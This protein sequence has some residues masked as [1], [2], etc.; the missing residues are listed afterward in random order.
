MEFFVPP[1]RGAALVRVLEAGRAT[2]GTRP[3]HC[4]PTTCACASTRPTSSATTPAARPTSS[5]SSPSAG[6][7][8]RASPTAATSTS[9]ST[10][11]TRARSSSTSTR[12]RASATSRTS[13]SPPPAPTARR[14]PSWS[15]PT[16]RRRSRARPAPSSS[17][18]R[19]WRRS[20]SPCCRSCARTA[21]PSSRARS[22]APSAA[23]MQAEY[24]EGGSIGKRYRRQDEIGTPWCVTIDHQSLEDRTVTL[25]DRDSLA[26]ER[27]AIDE[28]A[29]PAGGPRARALALAEA[30]RGLAGA[31]DDRPPP[32]RRR[33]PPG[34]GPG[35]AVAPEASSSTAKP[36]RPTSSGSWN[37]STGRPT[38]AQSSRNDSQVQTDQWRS[39]SDRKPRA[40]RSTSS[41][42]GVTGPVAVERPV[43]VGHDEED[44]AGRDAAPLLQRGDRVGHVLDDVRGQDEVVL[45]VGEGQRVPVRPDV[46][47]H[48]PADDLLLLPAVEVAVGPVDVDRVQPEALRGGPADLDPAQAVEA[49]VGEARVA[50]ERASTRARGWRATNP[51]GNRW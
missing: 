11:G 48:R 40:C 9:P 3:R 21:S 31:E 7:S 47:G 6:P 14:S 18:T 23:S 35:G 19:G 51:S 37:S 5:T 45:V 13:S 4:G 29:G 27:V 2:T 15:T 43:P 46:H 32:A 30:R 25:R 50:L 8:S 42:T 24:D 39:S 22:S 1:E 49:L 17:S 44:V 33:G 12:P 10:P 28:L 16:T 26:Q 38:C 20:R 41:C 36:L 34:P